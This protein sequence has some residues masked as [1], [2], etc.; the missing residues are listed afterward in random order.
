MAPPQWLGPVIAAV[1][2]KPVRIVFHNLLP[3][4]TDGDLFIPVDTHD[5]GRGYGPA[6]PCRRPSTQ[7]SVID[8]VRNPICSEY[9]TPLQCFKQNRA[10]LHLHGGITPWISDGTPDQWG[11]P[12]DEDTPWPEGVDVRGVPDMD[13]G[14]DPQ[15]RRHDLLL[16][17]P[18]ELALPLDPRPL[19]GHHAPQR[20]RG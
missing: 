19:L 14:S 2:D 10:V 18:A 1:K 8:Q 9:P 11:T 17:Q 12:A 7:G 5:H 13:V 3:T 20:V 16:H 6:W 15:R 4:G